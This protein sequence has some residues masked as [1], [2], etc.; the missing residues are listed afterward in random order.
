MSTWNVS[1]Y[2]LHNPQFKFCSFLSIRFT[3]YYNLYLENCEIPITVTFRSSAVSPFSAWMSQAT[4]VSVIKIIHSEISDMYVCMWVF[5]WHF[6]YPFSN[7]NEN[8]NMVTAFSKNAKYE[9]WQM[10]VVSRPLSRRQFGEVNSHFTHLLC[11]RSYSQILS[12][13]SRHVL[14]F[15]CHNLCIF[16]FFILSCVG[17]LAKIRLNIYRH[18]FY[19]CLI[20]Y[21]I[22]Q[23]LKIPVC[24]SLMLLRSYYIPICLIPDIVL[25]IMSA[26]T[27]SHSRQQ[28]GCM[29]FYP[30]VM[31]VAAV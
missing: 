3:F 6:C 19:R 27:L 20:A 18:C 23:G 28:C 26:W 13:C 21:K 9:I 30:P 4:P 24:C 11:E 1:S 2:V 25:D 12:I 15:K 7:F 31:N 22:F 29:Y 16:C 10:S 17:L 14:T 8:W 5:M